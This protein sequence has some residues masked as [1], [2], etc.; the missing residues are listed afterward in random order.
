M[1]CSAIES[2]GTPVCFDHFSFLCKHFCTN[3]LSF[4]SW[5]TCLFENFLSDR[6]TNF[7]FLCGGIVLATFKM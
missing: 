6:V 4:S 1:Y 5:L 2:T 3:F 7:F